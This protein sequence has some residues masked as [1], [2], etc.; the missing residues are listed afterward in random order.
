MDP[1]LPQ[2]AKARKKGSDTEDIPKHR[3]TGTVRRKC[4]PLFHRCHTAVL[5]QVCHGVLMLLVGKSVSVVLMLCWWGLWA[6]PHPAPL[7]GGLWAS[8]LR[9]Q[10]FHYCILEKIGGYLWVITWIW[11]YERVRGR[12]KGQHF[13]KGTHKKQEHMI[14][15]QCKTVMYL[16]LSAVEEAPGLGVLVYKTWVGIMLNQEED[17]WL[18]V[19]SNL[20]IRFYIYVFGL[21]YQIL[22]MWLISNIV[23]VC[24]TDTSEALSQEKYCMQS[25][26]TLLTVD[27]VIAGNTGIVPP[28]K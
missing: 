6:S 4:S 14:M 21:L 26:M 19:G 28:S 5:G 18:P 20:W 9:V 10:V 25:P 22:H 11:I 23:E 8:L 3:D 24:G 2:W 13:R 27:A 17:A 15:L 16:H 7:R 12:L 1:C